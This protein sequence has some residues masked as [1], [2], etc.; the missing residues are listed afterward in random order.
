MTYRQ[1]F[2]LIHD[3]DDDIV[4]YDIERDEYYQATIKIAK[5]TDVLDKGTVYLQI[6]L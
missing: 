1:L 2:E 4:I 6:I 5:E 3:L